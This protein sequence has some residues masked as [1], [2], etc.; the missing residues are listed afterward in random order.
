MTFI[1]G[2]NSPNNKINSEWLKALFALSAIRLFSA[3]YTKRNKMKKK[4]N[5]YIG[6]WEE[7]V[8]KKIMLPYS[9]ESLIKV[10]I[11][12]K[13]ENSEYTHQDIAHWCDRFHMAMFDVETD[14]QMDIATGIAADVDA[15][16]D[17]FLSN[18]YS[19]EELQN[20]DFSL[21]R[22]PDEWFD[23]WLKQI[24]PV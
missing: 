12:G 1:L 21:I 22:L 14:S 3:L 23:N 8:S 17:M 20:L 2:G 5:K 9:V 24:K 16:W 7:P 18:T 4:K 6:K 19:L 15:Q 11:F 10:L 13:S